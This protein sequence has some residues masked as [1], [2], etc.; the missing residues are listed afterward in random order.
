MK[1]LVVFNLLAILATLMFLPSLAGASITFNDGI[2]HTIND[3]TYGYNHIFLDYDMSTPPNPGTHIDLVDG[4]YIHGLHLYN[5]STIAMS[6]GI[7][8]GVVDVH[9]NS[10]VDISGG[11]VGLD[12]NLYEN[13]SVMIRGGGV[14]LVVSY[15]SSHISMNKGQMSGDFAVTENS[16]GTITGG[17]LK[18]LSG[19]GSGSVTM[20]GG[21]VAGNLVSCDSSE[22]FLGGGIIDGLLAIYDDGMLYLDG[23]D[24]QVNGQSISSGDKLSDFSTICVE[25]TL[26]GSERYYSGTITGILADGTILDNEF[27]IYNLDDHEG[28]GDILVVP[29][30]ITLAL[31]GIGGLLLRKR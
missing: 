9:N 18:A 12:L 3:Y 6:G 1:N 19:M 13:S 4:G 24:F 23:K 25:E 5:N 20:T 22:F 31:F 27:R 26:M 28:A 21:V 16:T 7:I 2:H 15:G 29:E 11:V 30:P 17:Q 8:K 14:S 10:F